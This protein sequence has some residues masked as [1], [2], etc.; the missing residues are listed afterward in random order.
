MKLLQLV[1]RSTWAT[2][3]WCGVLP[4]G[5]NAPQNSPGQVGLS[6]ARGGG[7]GDRAPQNGRGLGLGLGWTLAPWLTAAAAGP[8]HHRLPLQ[9]REA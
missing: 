3:L 1:F 6:L 7:G 8:R 4:S 5:N 2:R 9:A